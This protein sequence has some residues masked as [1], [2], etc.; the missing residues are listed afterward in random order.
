MIILIVGMPGSGK[1]EFIKIGKKLGYNV[2][3]MGDVVRDFVKKQGFSLN[4]EIVGKIAN[5]E[6]QKQGMDIWAK[7]TLENLENFENVVIDGVRNMEEVEFFKKNN[8]NVQSIGVYCSPEIRYKRLKKR[9]RTDD[10]YNKKEFIERDER[11]RG[12]GLENVL[13]TCDYKITNEKTL[14]EYR[15]KVKE[16][17]TQLSS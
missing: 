8:R 11:E 3:T 15:E 5:S 2:I 14:G 12:W 1:D 16:L 6:R 7:R 17:L 13:E 9:A 10:I 4:N